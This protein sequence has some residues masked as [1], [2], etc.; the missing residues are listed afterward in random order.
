MAVIRTSSNG[1]RR[2]EKKTSESEAQPN[3]VLQHTNG[4]KVMALLPSQF[5]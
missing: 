5:P 3:G 4:R 1:K 2:L